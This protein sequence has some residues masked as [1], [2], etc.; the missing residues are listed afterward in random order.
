MDAI[1][2]AL[3]IA[4]DQLIQVDYSQLPAYAIAAMKEHPFQTI[5]EVGST[6]IVIV[7]GAISAPLLAVLGCSVE[8]PVAGMP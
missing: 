5:F 4:R 3:G 1:A 8:G 6:A 7:P 2:S